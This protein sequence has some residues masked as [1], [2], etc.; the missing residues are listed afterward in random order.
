MRINIHTAADYSPM[1][2]GEV[3]SDVCEAII[4]A[5]D[6]TYDLRYLQLA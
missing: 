1:C 4:A 3:V 2:L 6:H 5:T